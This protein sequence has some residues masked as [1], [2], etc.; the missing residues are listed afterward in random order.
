MVSQFPSS[1][2]KRG[3]VTD[4]TEHVL[5]KDVREYVD[6][7]TDWIFS[8]FYK[9]NHDFD[10]LHNLKDTIHGLLTITNTDPLNLGKT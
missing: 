1:Q 8:E 2:Q 10:R 7:N 5:G 3:W 9:L 6:R 4:T